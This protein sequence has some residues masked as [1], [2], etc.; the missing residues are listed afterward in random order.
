[1]LACLR[2][3]WLGFVSFLCVCVHLFSYI[4]FVDTR[5]RVCGV[6]CLLACSC[7]VLSDACI[8]VT[9]VPKAVLSAVAVIIVGVV[10]AHVVV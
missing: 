6:R 2:C 5:V 4:S 7:R 1:M 3:G 9:V 8:A 10:V